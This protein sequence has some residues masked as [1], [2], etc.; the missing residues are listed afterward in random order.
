MQKVCA[1]VVGERIARTDA[2][3]EIRWVCALFT[4][5]GLEVS[6]GTVLFETK[7]AILMVAYGARTDDIAVSAFLDKVA[8]SLKVSSS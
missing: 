2:I 6:V 8:R 1:G 4:V 3:V 5:D 7:G